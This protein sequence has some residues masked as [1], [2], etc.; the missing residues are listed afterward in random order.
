MF[1]KVTLWQSLGAVLSLFAIGGTLWFAMFRGNGSSETTLDSLG[2]KPQTEKSSHQKTKA[3]KTISTAGN[4]RLQAAGDCKSVLALSDSSAR[5]ES[6]LELVRRTPSLE[7]RKGILD[8]FTALAKEGQRF[9]AEWAA[10]WRAVTVA[11]PTGATQLLDSYLPPY[12]GGYNDVV[13]R[14]AKEWAITDPRGSANWLANSKTIDSNTHD[15]AFASLVAGYA[16]SDLYGAT[17]FALSSLEPH[18]TAYKGVVGALTLEALKKGWDTEVSRWFD[19]LPSDEYRIDAFSIVAG[20]IKETGNQKFVLWL[21]EN[22]GR[23]YRN[24]VVYNDYV[25]NIARNDPAAAMEF[26]FGLPPSPQDGT[27]T[28]V[29]T[30]ASAWLKADMPGL[31]RYYHGLSQ[32]SPAQVALKEGLQKALRWSPNQVRQSAKALFGF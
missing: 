16:Q 13:F 26:A 31:A 23:K 27:M 24:D 6:L 15:R 22:A 17:E 4:Q 30:A 21:K 32:D 1:Q 3:V 10:F 18:G 20:R 29:A 2:V 19:S 8:G 7:G 12:T 25:K 5:F 14:I 9:D 11:G 28:G